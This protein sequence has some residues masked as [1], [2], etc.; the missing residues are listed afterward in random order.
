MVSGFIPGCRTF[1]HIWI[2]E[3]TP[4][5]NVALNLGKI[6]YNEKR[7][8]IAA[9]PVPIAKCLDAE[10]R[11]EKKVDRK[12]CIKEVWEDK[13]INWNNA[14]EKLHFNDCMKGKGH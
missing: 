12:D 7:K 10:N 4:T 3:L 5:C 11:V 2:E 6:I 13:Q 9:L 14:L 8:Q 1:K